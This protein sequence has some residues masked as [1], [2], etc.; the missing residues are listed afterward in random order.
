MTQEHIDTAI[1]ITTVKD[2]VN[3]LHEDYKLEVIPFKGILPLL[4]S[5]KFMSKPEI[6]AVHERK[7][8]EFLE[9]LELWEPFSK[10]ELKCANC[11]VTISRENLAFIIPYG[12]RILVCC[13][14][15]ECMDY[16][17]KLRGGESNP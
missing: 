16:V 14:I 13:S 10:G 8:K 4:C 7:L 2:Y 9:K 5:V 12:D 1:Q 15:P 17:E 3:R 6:F 11:G